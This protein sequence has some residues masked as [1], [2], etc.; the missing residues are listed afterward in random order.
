MVSDWAAYFGIRCVCAG[1]DRHNRRNL[2][3]NVCQQVTPDASIL[4]DNFS[5]RDWCEGGQ[6]RL[7]L[8]ELSTC[9]GENRPLDRCHDTVRRASYVTSLPQ[10]VIKYRCILVDTVPTDMQRHQ[11]PTLCVSPLSPAILH[12]PCPL[13]KVS[14]AVWCWVRPPKLPSTSVHKGA[15]ENTC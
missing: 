6:F 8:T 1:G 11:I 2:E 13:A 10:G 5:A 14:D 7:L 12:A 9:L 3:S 4:P 15:G